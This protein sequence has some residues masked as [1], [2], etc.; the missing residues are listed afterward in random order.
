MKDIK[1]WLLL[2][3]TYGLLS[4]GLYFVLMELPPEASQGFVHKIF[5]F[6]V[7]S[8][9]SM[10][11]GLISGAILSGIYLFERKKIFDQLA[12]ACMYTATFFSIIVI[13]S[14]PIWAKPIWGVYWTWD[15]RLTTT[16]VVFILLV[17]YCFVRYLFKERENHPQ[18]G[19]L[20]GA[21]L[22]I[23]AVLD[24]PLVHFSVKLWRG[25]HPSVVQNK[26]G[27][28]PD[29]RTGLELMSLALLVMAALT[30]YLFYKLIWLTE[31]KDEL[32]G[33]SLQ[34]AQGVRN[35]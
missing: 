16:F 5:F 4:Y 23:F 11:F 19:A 17:G 7:P 2:V 8:A 32:M 13:T 30:T 21:I 22:A 28:P 35:A 14:G 20:I 26:E 27:L 12:R 31:M 24:I 9:F 33:K 6:H 10:Y 34:S 1:P 29:F 15:P 3:V 18:R 25:I